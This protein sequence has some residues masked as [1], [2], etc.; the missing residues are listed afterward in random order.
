[1][2][3]S[4]GLL[5]ALFCFMCFTKFSCFTKEMI[6]K[7]IRIKNTTGVPIICV[8]SSI[9]PD[10]ALSFT[11]KMRM[12]ANNSGI[13]TNYIPADDSLRIIRYAVGFKENWDSHFH[14]DTMLLFVFEQEVVDSNDWSKVV[15]DYMVFRRLRITYDEFVANNYI[16]NIE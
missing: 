10:T 16:I 11:S 1:M 9:Y 8:P 7:A 13:Y 12:E 6:E 4:R 2:S 15:V 14:S 5:F 3:K